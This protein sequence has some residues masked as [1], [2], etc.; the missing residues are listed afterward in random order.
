MNYEKYSYGAYNLHIINTNKFKTIKVTVNFRTKSLENEITIRNILKMILLNSCKDYPK[1]KD[2]IIESENLYDL[3]VSSLSSRVGN[4]SILSF[5]LEFLNEKYTEKNMNEYSLDFFMNLLFKP[6]VQDNK[7]DQTS[8]NVVTNVLRKSINSIKD[9]KTKYSIIKVLEVMNHNMPYSFNPFGKIE[10]LDSITPE[11]LYEYYKK[12]LT[13]DLVDILVVGEVDS[14]KIREYFT[15]NFKV[16]TY[17]KVKNDILLPN[18]LPR[19]KV[20][21][22]IEKDNVNQSKLAI[23][24]RISNMTDY[25]RKYVL[26]VYNEILGGGGNSMLF[27]TIRE[28]HSLA[29]YINSFSQFYDNIAIIYAGVNSSKINMAIKLIKDTLNKMGK[30][31]F[32]D[33]DLNNAIQTIISAI[34]VSEDSNT[35]II[36]NYYAQ[37]LVNADNLDIKIKKYSNIT[38]EDVVNIAKK[39]KMDTIYILEGDINEND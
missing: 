22:I 38:K 1:E 24:L 26:R 15:N 14:E 35:G 10:E 12:V 30:G 32:S 31:I 19:K 13:N 27:N 16:N 7:F 11:S 29:Y 33:E 36:N 17:K 39:I 37:S 20:K 34:E 6:N 9:N 2:L 5:N 23:G 18:I 21:K 3:K 4:Y 28:K 25:E 8:F